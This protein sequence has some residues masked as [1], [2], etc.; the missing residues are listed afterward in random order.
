MHAC[1]C[2]HVCV[3]VLIPKLNNYRPESYMSWFCM[4]LHGFLLSVLNTKECMP[5][6]SSKKHRKISQNNNLTRTEKRVNI[7]TLRS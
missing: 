1:M 6:K 4:A 5:H 7:E 2:V 3:C